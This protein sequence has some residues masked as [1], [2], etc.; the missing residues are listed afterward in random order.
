[1]TLHR[2]EPL[3]EVRELLDAMP[4][5]DPLLCDELAELGRHLLAVARSAQD[6]QLPGSIERQIERSQTDKK[7]KPLQVGGRVAPIPVRLP[8]RRR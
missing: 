4:N 5:L 1:M 2:P 3:V 8:R 7:T 6:G